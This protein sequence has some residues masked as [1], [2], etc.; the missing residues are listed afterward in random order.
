[1]ISPKENISR[2]ILRISSITARFYRISDKNRELMLTPFRLK[3]ER[4]VRAE[5]ELKLPIELLGAKS[6]DNSGF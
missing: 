3:S 2:G 1:M 5:W 6:L 4:L